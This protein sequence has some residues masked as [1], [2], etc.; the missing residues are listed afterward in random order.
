MAEVEIVAAGA[1][2]SIQEIDRLGLGHGVAQR[3]DQHRVLEHVG[4]APGMEGVA[5]AEH[6]SPR[7]P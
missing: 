1:G 5:I 4:E 3:M 7:G 2:M 6:E